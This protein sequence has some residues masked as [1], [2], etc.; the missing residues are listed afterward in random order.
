M[1]QAP[2]HNVSMD[3]SLTIVLDRFERSLT[4]QNNAIQ[5]ILALSA[6]SFRE[7]YQSTAKPC[8][9]KD[10][11]EFD[12]WLDDVQRLATLTKKGPEDVALAT[13]RGLL[14]RH[15]RELHNNGSTWEAIKTQLQGTFS[16]YGSSTMARHRL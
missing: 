6:N 5:K 2:T 15:V 7:H 8:D 10:P 1:A 9:G 13:S 11:K 3:N 4:L 14:H 12:H 16:D